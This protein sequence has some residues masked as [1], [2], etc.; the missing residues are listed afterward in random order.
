M[1]MIFKIVLFLWF[2]AFAAAANAQTVLQGD[3]LYRGLQIGK[4]TFED[5]K[6][7]MGSGYNT[8]D[9][10]GESNGLLRDGRCIIIRRVIG[11]KVFYRKRGVTF[12]VRSNS[13]REWLAGIDFNSNSTVQSSKGI[14]PGRHTFADVVACYGSVDFN[15]KE[16]EEPQLEESCEDGEQWMTSIVFP[17]I[18]FRSVG[19]RQPGENILLR[20]IEIIRLANE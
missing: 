9:I 8:E 3:S 19:K 13:K 18:S 2:T 20:R 12:Y 14:M 17:S 10:I 16:N 15:K 4:A 7:V 6:R 5:I 1:K 11:Q